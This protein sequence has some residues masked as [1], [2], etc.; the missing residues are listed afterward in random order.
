[1][2]TSLLH[3]VNPASVADFGILHVMNFDTQRTRVARGEQVEL[4]ATIATPSA[5]GMHLDYFALV[6]ENVNRLES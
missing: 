2:T 4:T 3:I 6:G 5:L 1:V